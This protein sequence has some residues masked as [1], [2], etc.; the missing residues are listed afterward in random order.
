MT[1]RREANTEG[2]G[3]YRGGHGRQ[4]EG[5]CEMEGERRNGKKR[6]TVKEEGR[7]GKMKYRGGASSS[8]VTIKEKSKI[9]YNNY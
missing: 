2:G 7:E 8:K 5:G 9:I 6:K 4:W 3:M 1:V